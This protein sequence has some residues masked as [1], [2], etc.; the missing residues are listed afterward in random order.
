MRA[1]INIRLDYEQAK[2][3]V[4]IM[5]VLRKRP[6]QFNKTAPTKKKYPRKKPIPIEE[7]MV[8]KDQEDRCHEEPPQ[9]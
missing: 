9:S 8:E 5:Q 1:V 7:G 2:K 6:L 4:S 3:I